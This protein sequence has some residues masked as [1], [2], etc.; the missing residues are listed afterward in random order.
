MGSD[1]LVAPRAGQRHEALKDGRAGEL[2][3]EKHQIALAPSAL[4]NAI[5]LQPSEDHSLSGLPL[6]LLPN[7]HTANAL[8]A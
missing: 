1:A 2:E 8:L 7:G 4:L 5:D 3:R 6:A